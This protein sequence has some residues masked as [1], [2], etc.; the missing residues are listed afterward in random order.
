MIEI[1]LTK[2]QI[3]DYRRI[4]AIKYQE[5]IRKGHKGGADIIKQLMKKI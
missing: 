5:C 2:Q 3:R 1:T 4:L